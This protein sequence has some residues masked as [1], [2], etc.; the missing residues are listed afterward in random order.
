MRSVTLSV[1]NIAAAALVAAC[2]GGVGKGIVD[3]GPTPQDYGSLTF[4]DVS[5]DAVGPNRIAFHRDAGL[6]SHGLVMVDGNARTA[7]STSSHYGREVAL[8]PDGSRI[9]YIGAPP[10]SETDQ[11]AAEVFVRPWAS[12]TG[13]PIAGPG[14]RRSVPSWSPD[15]TKI[16]FA[17]GDTYG[18]TPFPRIISQS[19]V[20]N[21]SDRQTIWTAGVC[22]SADLPSQNQNGDVAFVYTGAVPTCSLR[23]MIAVTKGGTT[24]VIFDN[25]SAP[26]TL[27]AP[28]WSPSGAEIAFLA[29][30][31]SSQQT[32]DGLVGLHLNVMSVDGSNSR[33]LAI[34]VKS[35]PSFFSAPSLCWAK[36]GSRLFVGLG[37]SGAI[38]H[39]YSIRADG[40]GFMPVTTAAVADGWVPRLATVANWRKYLL[41][42]GAD[43][44]ATLSSKKRRQNSSRARRTSRSRGPRHLSSRAVRSNNSSARSRAPSNRFVFPDSQLRI[45]L[46]TSL[47]TFASC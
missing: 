2:G 5:Y 6:H 34:P 37:I 32:G 12:I 8:S 27:Y 17:E 25:L 13:T 46:S 18:L 20:A 45:A 42:P 1:R 41:N 15:G 23:Q 31:P 33:I 10:A 22:E 38:G 4:A 16:L 43:A 26:S 36:D 29:N 39:I 3:P 44:G 7:T 21:A 28:E 40:S 30:N 24:K 35:D 9:V 14:G 19:P 47:P 11:R